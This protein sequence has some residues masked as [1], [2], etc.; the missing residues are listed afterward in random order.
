LRRG[1]VGE[2][3]TLNVKQGRGKKPQGNRRDGHHTEI[4]GHE[5]SSLHGKRERGGKNRLGIVRGGD[6]P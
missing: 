6:F 3:A 2:E 5:K 4:M 1:V